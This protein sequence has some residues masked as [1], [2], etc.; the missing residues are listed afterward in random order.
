YLTDII[1]MA[2]KDKIQIRPLIVVSEVEVTG[3]NDKA[4]LAQLEAARRAQ[5]AREL[6]LAGVTLADPARLDVRGTLTHGS[7]VFID[8]NV[9]FEGRVSLGDRVR[10]GPNCI[11]KDAEIGDAVEVH[12]HCTIDRASIGP[13]CSVGPYARLRPGARLAR[14]AH[15]GN[16][17]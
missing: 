17:V 14:G 2:V 6:M 13:G 8:V 5:V 15:I 4:Q 12:S 16:F 10:I 11:I 1:A 3:V 9:V 7:D